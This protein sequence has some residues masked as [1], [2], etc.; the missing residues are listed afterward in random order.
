[1]DEET[2]QDIYSKLRAIR[3]ARGLTV[4]KLAEKMGENSQKIGRIERGKSNLTVDY[5]LKVSKALGISM[6][7]ILEEEKEKTASK[8]MDQDLLS[9]IIQ[10]VEKNIEAMPNK[11]SGEEKANLISHIFSKASQVPSQFGQHVVDGIVE[12]LPIL[13]K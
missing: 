3:R 13:T 10:S 9:Y 6:D 8:R 11:L 1:M 7:T 4:D 12:T 2:Q 5:L